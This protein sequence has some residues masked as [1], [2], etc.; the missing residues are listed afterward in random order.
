MVEGI[1]LGKGQE[2]PLPK[3][4]RHVEGVR[5]NPD[6]KGGQCLGDGRQQWQM[7]QRGQAGYTPEHSLPWS[8]R[9]PLGAA[10]WSGGGSESGW[11]RGSTHRTF[12]SRLQSLSCEGNRKC[13]E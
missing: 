4:I 5:E 10:Q 3:E 9:S 13:V 11:R 8:P 6:N 1:A 2:G 7:P 12:T